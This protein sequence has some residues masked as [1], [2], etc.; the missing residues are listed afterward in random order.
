M[1]NQSELVRALRKELAAKEKELADQKWVFEQFLQSPSWRWTAPIRWVANQFR[2]LRN[3]H[4]SADPA[5]IADDSPEEANETPA[6]E[7]TDWKSD[8][9]SLCQ[10][11]LE[12]FLNSGAVLN[13][14]SS[15]KP[16]ISIVLVLF[17]RAEL[18]LACLRSITENLVEHIEVIIV[19]NASSDATPRLLNVCVGRAFCATVRI[20]TFFW[21]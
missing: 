14:P 10:V 8:F 12:G 11:T 6:T 16:R 21:A 2:N 4:P 17:N 3:G 5:K 15:L 1:K 13:L 18:T 9:T 20:A 19:D 7:S